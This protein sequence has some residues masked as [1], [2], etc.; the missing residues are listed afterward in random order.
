M[1]I[2]DNTL[3]DSTI[4]IHIY[5]IYKVFGINN[6]TTYEYTNF[7]SWTITTH[8]NNTTTNIVYLFIDTLYNDAFG[9]WV[10]E[11]AIYLPLFKILKEIYPSIKLVLKHK[12]KFKILFCKYFDIDISDIV[13][14]IDISS[15]TSC[16]FP[17]PI[18]A[19]N[20]IECSLQFQT[21]LDKFW[22]YFRSKSISDDISNSYL[23]NLMPRQLKE[24][25]K[26]NDRKIN[27][28]NIIKFIET[29]PNSKI[30]NTDDLD[31]LDEQ[32]D[33]I[34]KSY[35]TTITDGSPLLV[36]GMFCY[37]KYL[38]VA[39]NLCTNEQSNTYNKLAYIISKIKKQN[40]LLEYESNTLLVEKKIFH[41]LN[42]L[43][44]I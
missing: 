30:T 38:L 42:T 3:P 6:V 26:Y 21:Q 35:I 36:N 25:F 18:S 31:D 23:V 16:L 20:N 8:N 22:N 24:N 17:S 19:L 9:H 28:D 29:L 32:I 7:N 39:G 13:Y 5:D 15:Q 14:D 12:K 2:F 43:H 44:L 41:I 1:I 33:I 37:N 34:R 11:S 10:Y 40:I 27:I 4:S